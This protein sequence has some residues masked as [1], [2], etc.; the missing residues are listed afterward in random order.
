M[1]GGFIP[2]FVGTAILAGVTAL[3]RLRWSR[4]PVYQRLNQKIGQLKNAPQAA[5]TSFALR[6]ETP[7]FSDRLAIVGEF[8]S[9]ELIEAI[10]TEIAP[11]VAERSFIPGHK[12][13][14]TVAYERLIAHAPVTVGFYHSAEF[15]TF[16]SRTV[17]VRVQPTPVCDQ[18]SLSVLVYSRPG[19]HIGWHYDHNFY[20]GRHFT[21]LLIIRNEGADQ[22]QL[23]HCV[24]SINRHGK[25]AT[26]PTPAN[27][28]VVFEGARILHMVTPVRENETRIALSMTY[29]TNDRAWWWQGI[30]R[31]MK[32]TAFFGLRAL[33]T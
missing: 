26:I 16:I 18:S 25:V 5:R 7:D 13:G 6:L 11:L 22:K 12:Q 28:L 27:S 15:Q 17:G 10:R 20:Q 19:D 30:A 9:S 24:L 4:I 23:S 21:V 1:F 2:A 31:R 3:V 14:G 33:W 29:C 8:L 32:D